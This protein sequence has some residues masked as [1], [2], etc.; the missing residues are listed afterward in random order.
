MYRPRGA[1]LWC[2]ELSHSTHDVSHSA[3]Q[4]LKNFPAFHGTRMFFIVFIRGL[5]QSLIWSR[6]IQFIP[7]HS[8]LSSILILSTHLC[9]V[10]PS[11]LLSSVFPTNILYALIFSFIHATCLA[12]SFSL[13]S[14]F[15]FPPPSQ[16]GAAIPL[17]SLFSVNC[18]PCACSR[19]RDPS[20]ARSE[21]LKLNSVAWV[22]ETT[23][24]TE[25]Q[26]F[27]DEVSTNF[28]RLRISRDQ[29]G[30][31]LLPYSRFSRPEPLSFLPSSSSI[32]LTRLSGPRSRHTTSQKSGSA[33]NRTRTSG[34]V[35]RNSDHRHH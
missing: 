26:P 5:H 18:S 1:V 20:R 24:S 12:I 29:R 28:C 27:V 9:L 25:R 3:T 6:S 34:S 32:V 17:G 31:Y 7:L 16:L 19:V 21:L 4:P 15:P 33:G 35:A 2:M 23:I 30:G 10:L 8:V 22:R 14:S 13:T 11:G